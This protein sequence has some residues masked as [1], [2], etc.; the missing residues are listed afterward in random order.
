MQQAER[1]ELGQVVYKKKSWTET[2]DQ[3]AAIRAA[4]TGVLNM[5]VCP[6]L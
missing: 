5:C 3:Y 4:H 6:H 1:L 2:V